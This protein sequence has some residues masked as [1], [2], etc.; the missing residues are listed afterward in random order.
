MGHEKKTEPQRL[1]SERDP[2]WS[3]Y[4]MGSI[5]HGDSECFLCSTLV[6]RRKPSLSIFLPSSK[7][8]IFLIMLKNKA[9]FP[10][11]FFQMCE[12]YVK[13]NATFFWQSFILIINVSMWSTKLDWQPLHPILGTSV[14]DN[15]RSSL[16]HCFIPNHCWKKVFL[17][18]KVNIN[19]FSNLYYF[20]FLIWEQAM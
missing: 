1:Y 2:I 11:V 13:I 18:W 5:P 12:S 16:I 8:S 3:P 20:F 9:L 10:Q 7:L 17:W 4:D 14:E 19:Y 15:F 6:T